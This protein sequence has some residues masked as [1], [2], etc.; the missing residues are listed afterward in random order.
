MY[1]IV[2]AGATQQKVAVGDVIEIDKVTTK[3]GES[4]TLPV[5]MVVDGEEHDHHESGPALHVPVK[6]RGS[7][8]R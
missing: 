4:F 1:A 3:V 7:R 2:R 8:K 6:R 5:V